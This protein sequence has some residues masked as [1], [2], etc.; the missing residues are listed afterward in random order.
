[1]ECLLGGDGKKGSRAKHWFDS[2]TRRSMVYFC[3][4][5]M[6]LYMFWCENFSLLSI[7]AEFRKKERRF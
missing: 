6:D 2:I 4:I 7:F 3:F 1:M 5:M